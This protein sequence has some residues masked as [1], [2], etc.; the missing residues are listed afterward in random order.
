EL[1]IEAARLYV[2]IKRYK[3]LF[4]NPIKLLVFLAIY[5]VHMSAYLLKRGAITAWPEI[6][7]R[8][9]IHLLLWQQKEVEQPEAVSSIIVS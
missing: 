5:F 7:R 4:P 8:S 6:I 3:N 2:G 1:H 9:Q